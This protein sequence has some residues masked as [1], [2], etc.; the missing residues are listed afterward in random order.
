MP[1]VPVGRLLPVGV[2]PTHDAMPEPPWSSAHEN[3]SGTGRPCVYTAP[4]G[5][6]TVTVGATVSTRNDCDCTAPWL[7][8]MSTPNHLTVVTPGFEIGMTWPTLRARWASYVGEDSVGVEP[9]VV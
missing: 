1:V 6:L 2:E 5:M 8:L 4:S 3:V 9:S 7:P